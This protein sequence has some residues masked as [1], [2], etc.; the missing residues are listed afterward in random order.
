MVDRDREVRV[1]RGA[2]ADAV[3]GQG[4]LA[5]IHGPAGIG[6]SRLLQEV[7]RLAADEG[8]LV[9]TARGSQLE[10]SFAFGAVRQLFEGTLSDPA[11]RVE[12]LRGSA[13]SAASVFGEIPAIDPA[14]RADGSFAVL[15]GLYWLTVNLA[16]QQPV[17]L[18]VDDVQWCDTGS[19]RALA[20]LLR[21]LEGLPVLIAATLRTGEPHEDEALLAELA[22]DLA[23]VQVHP[24]P[25]APEATAELVR[26][27][28][29]A[30]AH[31]S[32]I[33]ACHR[34]TGGNPLLLRQLLRALQVEGV[35]PDASHA[36][37]V[38]AIGSRA[39][40]SMV[41]MRLTRLPA[42]C[43]AVARAVAVLGDGCL[44]AD[45]AA[46]AGLDEPTTATALAALARAEVVRAGLPARASCTRWSATPST[47]P[48]PSGE[49]ELH[50]ERAAAVLQA[51]GRD[52]RAGRRPPA[53]SPRC[54]AAPTRCGCCGWRPRPPPSAAPPTP[55]R[56][57]SSG[58]S[59]SRPRPPSGPASCSSWAGWAP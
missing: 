29:G 57:T 33:A 36:D 59:P 11:Q 45:V 3:D 51:R 20:F 56:P 18:A 19:L 48:C 37:T 50:H 39:V 41:L 38:N 55:H 6:K 27:R 21:R 15:H 2:L 22:E 7:R 32:F 46:L 28:L 52:P 8:A 43:T 4:R 49:R 42:D 12:L 26:D 13:S 24:G 53:C 25:L 5:L 35:R 9:L 31:D 16:E 10:R 23:T 44:L 58:P 40:S 47:R 14:E 30:D 34:T 54:A 1:L 17:V